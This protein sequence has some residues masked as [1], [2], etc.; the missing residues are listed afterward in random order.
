MRRRGVPLIVI[1]L[2]CAI[3]IAMSAASLR[4]Y[5][6]PIDTFPP[7]DAT[8][9]VEQPTSFSAG[10]VAT[11]IAAGDIAACGAG[12][13]EQTARLLATIDGTIQTLGDNAY[14]SGTAAEFANCFDRTWGQFRERMRPAVGNHEYYTPNAAAYFKYFGAA[15]GQSSN[16][17]YSYDLGS[18]HIVVLNGECG[19]VGGCGPSS[20]EAIW[21]RL[22][23]QAS[24]ATCT[25]AVWHE[26][27]WSSGAEHGSDP[28]YGTFWTELDS[29]G[30][31][32][33]LNGHDHDYERFAPQTPDGKP[34][35]ATGVREF[36]VGTGG[37]SLYPV[38]APIANSEVLR[39]D[40]Y[41]VLVLTLR[42]SGYD[43]R[44]VPVEGSSFTDSGSG[45]CH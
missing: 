4:A 29:A 22:D 36:V 24:T 40:T 30:A 35:S 44:F 11:L 25:L 23:L 8:P 5:E 20:P 6:P 28:R 1:L 34:D 2:L 14:E 38:R 15:A 43:W 10:P 37:R 27:R 45:V 41:G 19:A 21:L 7:A 31:E 32:I 16:G 42:T 18:W 17:Y 3:F 12:E 39:D 33:V 13:S 26:P 9:S